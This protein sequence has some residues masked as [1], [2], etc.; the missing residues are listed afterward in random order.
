MET[1]FS[2]ATCDLLKLVAAQQVTDEG[3]QRF[4]PSHL[5]SKAEPNMDDYTIAFGMI[6][7]ALVVVT[8]QAWKQGN[9]KRDVVLLG[10]ISGLSGIGTLTFWAA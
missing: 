2:G 7:A 4:N 3:Y 10:L 5:Q 9:E 1:H 6:T 8:I